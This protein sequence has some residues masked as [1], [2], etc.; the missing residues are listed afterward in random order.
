M[1]ILLTRLNSEA[2]ELIPLI[3]LGYLATAIRK[4]QEVE[5][6]DC[7]KDNINSDDLV[8]YLKHKSFDVVGMTFYTMNY[9]VVKEAS[10]KI[11]KNFPNILIFVGGPHPSAVPKEVLKEFPYI[12]YAFVGEAEIGLPILLKKLKERSYQK[13]ALRRCHRLRSEAKTIL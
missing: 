11:K 6:L 2:D 9:E 4:N 10:E 8:E 1:K 3:G 7:L 12:D 5:I 13:K